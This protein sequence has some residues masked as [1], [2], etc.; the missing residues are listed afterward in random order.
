[1]SRWWLGWV[2][3]CAITASACE[4]P[5][6]VDCAPGRF[7]RVDGDAWCVYDRRATT[8]CPSPLPVEHE[9]AGGARACAETLHEPPPLVLCVIAGAC[10]GD[11]GR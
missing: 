3:G 4:S 8:R 9:L 10:P 5:L 7:A 1:M 2:A 6:I 11:A